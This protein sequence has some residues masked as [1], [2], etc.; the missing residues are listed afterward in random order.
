[1]PGKV[2]QNELHKMNLV[3]V[4]TDNI[5]HDVTK[6]KSSHAGRTRA[7]RAAQN[8]MNVIKV[9][10]VQWVLQFLCI[11][12][13]K[14]NFGILASKFQI[15]VFIFIFYKEHWIFE[16]DIKVPWEPKMPIGRLCHASN[17]SFFRCQSNGA[18]KWGC[19][20]PVPEVFLSYSVA[21]RE[22]NLWQPG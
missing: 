16:F 5:G 13:P 14:F 1:M 4:A 10:T 7:R 18:W 20:R 21:L 12:P 8:W 17:Y 2:Q 19:Q 3:N 6:S 9:A 15:W 11:R 22:K